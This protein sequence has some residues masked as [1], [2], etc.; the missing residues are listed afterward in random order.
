MPKPAA[1]KIAVAAANDG[2]INDHMVIQRTA[3]AQ[4]ADTIGALIDG[5]GSRP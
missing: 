5:L 2:H 1:H 3:S 4:P